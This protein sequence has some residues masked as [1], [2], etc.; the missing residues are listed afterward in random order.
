MKKTSASALPVSDAAWIKLNEVS[1]PGESRKVPRRNTP[2]VVA[3]QTGP[4]LLEDTC[5]SSPG[6]CASIAGTCR[7]QGGRACGSHRT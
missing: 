3:G 5:V 7:G 2:A 4:R 1:H 6:P